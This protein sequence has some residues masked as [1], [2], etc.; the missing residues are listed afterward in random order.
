MVNL[1]FFQGNENRN[2]KTQPEMVERWE[3]ALR[4]V[5]K[6][7]GFSLEYYRNDEFA[8][9]AAIVRE[10]KRQLHMQTETELSIVFVAF[11]ALFLNLLFS[12]IIAPLLFPDLKF[13]QTRK[14]LLGF[15]GL[16]LALQV[17]YKKNQNEALPPS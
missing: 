9:V 17:W 2:T 4:S 15:P 1:P 11:L 7:I 10:V 12:F 13:F 3:C 16:V 8:F 6:R 5:T 14:W